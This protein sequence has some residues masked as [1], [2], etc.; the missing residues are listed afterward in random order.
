MAVSLVVAVQEFLM[1]VISVAILSR[2]SSMVVDNIVKISQFFRVSQVA[3][4]FVLLAVATSLPEL[5][6]SVVAS[7]LGEGAI[8]AGNVFGS[9]IA[10]VLL[11]LGVGAYLYGIKISTTD[12]KDIGLVLL[13]TTIISVYI[14]YNSSVQQKALGFLEGILLL[15]MFAAYVW[16]T[17]TKRKFEDA[18]GNGQ[19]TKKDAL[20]A[21][22]VF[23][24][25]LLLVLVSSGFV[26][27]SAVSIAKMF[28]ISESFIGATIIAIGTSLPELSVDLQ[29]IRKRQYGVAL[30]DAI[31]SNM[32]NLTLVL[33]AAAAINPISITLPVFIAALLFA[34]IANSLLL[35][36]AAAHRG[37][38]RRGGTLFLAIYVVYLIVEF[39]LQINEMPAS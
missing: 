3:I 23:G 9:N 11:I 24:I 6:V 37:L 32:A 5:S 18:D 15:T 39:T 4:G 2:A 26:V 19:V 7:G 10:N 20:N 29:A 27:S 21:F 12:M 13:L 17:L 30:G 33:G 35:Y 36:V 16:Y 25:G 31:G 38:K 8:A 28:G 14:I 1:L 22:L 34:I